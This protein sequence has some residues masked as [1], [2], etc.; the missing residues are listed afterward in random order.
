M[1][2][3][4]PHMANIR[5]IR[6]W[7]TV[8]E[9]LLWKGRAVK[10]VAWQL[11]PVEEGDYRAAFYVSRRQ[12]PSGGVRIGNTDYKAWW[13]ERGV[14]AHGLHPGYQAHYVLRIALESSRE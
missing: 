6:T 1:G 5:R 9:H 14:R 11:S 10:D 13:I 12:G 7:P 8:T 3:F 2:E 4:I